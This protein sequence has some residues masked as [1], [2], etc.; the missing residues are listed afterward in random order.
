MLFLKSKEFMIPFMKTMDF[1]QQKVET[2]LASAKGRTFFFFK[3][4]LPEQI[5]FLTGHS[6]SLFSCQ[7]FFGADGLC[8]DALLS[9][10]TALAQAFCSAAEPRVGFYEELLVLRD[11]LPQSAWD[12]ILIIENNLLAPWSPACIPPDDALAL[13]D[14]LQADYETTDPKI[15]LLLSFYG[16]VQ[17]VEHQFLLLPAPVDI[18][19]LEILPFWSGNAVPADAEPSWLRIEP[20]TPLDWRFRL[21]VTA[22][23]AA[24]AILLVYDAS[25]TPQQ[26]ILATALTA[27]SCPFAY[28]RERDSIGT[29]EACLSLLHRY[30]GEDAS[31]RPLLFYRNPEESHETESISQGQI[32]A[33][34]VDQCERAYAGEDFRHIFITAPTGA[35]KSML[36]QLPALHLAEEHGLVTLVIS[37]LIALMN[38]QVNQL[39]EQRGIDT[40]V[41]INSTMTINER[42]EAVRSLQDGS[43]SLLYL[44]PELLLNIQLK[45]FL[46]TRRIGL[47]VIDEAHT[48]TSWGRDFR[49]DYW[50]L[51]DFLKKASRDGYSFPVLCLTATAVYGGA[52]DVVNDT[53]RELGLGR[54]LLHLGR[55]R[56]DNISFDI[57]RHE[58]EETKESV[59]SQKL[60]LMLQRVR[61]YVSRREKVLAYFPFRSQVDQIY[62]LTDSGDHERLRRYHGQLAAPE[63]L[64]VEHD[65]RTGHAMGL[66]CT[67][68]FGMGVDVPDIKHVIHFAPTG[69]LSDYIQEIGRIARE[70]KIRGVA[71]VDYFNTDLHYVRTLNQL[72]EM[73]Q[74]QLRDMLRKLCTLYASGTSQN[75]LI[76]PEAF[77][78]LFPD[79]DIENR[80][81]TG[82]MLLAKDLSDK[83][84]YPVLVVRPRAALSKTFVNVPSEIEDAWLRKYGAFA[85]LQ[86]GTGM[87][88]IASS[89]LNRCSDTLIYSSGN[90][91]QVDMAAAWAACRPELTFGMFRQAFFAETFTV[92][93]SASNVMPRVRVDIH[94]S[95]PYDEVLERV[96]ALLAGIVRIFSR[97]RNAEVKHFSRADFEADLVEQF[98]E[99]PV[100]HEK[101][102]LLMDIFVEDPGENSALSGGRSRIRV[103]RR[104][105]QTAG[106]DPQFFVSTATYSALESFFMH[107]LQQCVPNTDSDELFRRFYP[108]IANKPLEIMSLLRLLELTGLATY[109]ICG[110]EKSEI[111]VRI[112]EPAYL[113]S[114][115]DGKYSNHIL[116]AIHQRH[117]NSQKLL[118]AFFTHEM[119]SAERWELIEDY[120][121][122]REQAVSD[123]LHLSEGS[124]T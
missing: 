30:W 93:S 13:F 102:G 89:N 70:Q 59:E 117:E 76:A 122:G 42:M 22:G 23:N 11:I 56:R 123:A 63:R 24:P 60:Q 112:N 100:S 43:R 47:V 54:V 114:L 90:T 81:K 87:R 35:G 67:K 58:I 111:F 46:G 64:K 110:S 107:Q 92:G 73:R 75:L 53:I 108:L 14:C 80:T 88:R 52:D 20:D 98:G 7:D 33:E 121:L 65:Y 84:H 44:A 79:E 104:R 4:F 21:S 74:Y 101:V 45:S 85:V 57:R 62:S 78:Y 82:L 48:V 72:S 51:G 55:V 3:G 120:F 96:H 97:H 27:S 29:S 94:Y 115:A 119:T 8:L 69:A 16:D 2:L 12:H 36:F 1:F 118:G 77:S 71:H 116:Q 95:C 86:D 31:F 19:N 26:E 61:K 34:I 83:C 99:K 105:K 103:L 113:Q 109:E 39:R 25:P 28:V 68:A 50:F 124:A 38:D 66:F 41:C 18:P 40:A 37:P 17:M 9:A 5:R 32:V 49:S 10:Q 91:Y 106:I 6:A 15:R